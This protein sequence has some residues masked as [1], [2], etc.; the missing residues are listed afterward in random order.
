MNQLMENID[1]SISMHC[2]QIGKKASIINFLDSLKFI[3]V[4]EIKKIEIPSYSEN[5]GQEFNKNFGDNDLSV[6]CKYY[7]DQLSK[8]KSPI[9][10][11]YL[12]IVVSG[13]KSIRVFDNQSATISSSLNLFKNM[14]LVLPKNT[15]ISELISKETFIIDVI[16]NNKNID[17]EK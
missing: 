5:D 11:D 17:I 3:L 10:K 7:S 8:I 14:G 15:I 4:D 12:S 2:E 9:T 13:Q 1:K 16:S 6:I